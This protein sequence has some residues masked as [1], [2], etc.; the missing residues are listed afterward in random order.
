MTALTDAET[1]AFETPAAPA[2]VRND[3]LDALRLLAAL[4]VVWIHSFDTRPAPSPQDMGRFAVPFFTV[5]SVWLMARRPTPREPAGVAAFAWL[6]FVRRRFVRL[7]VPFLIWN[8]VYTMMREAKLRLLHTGEPTTFDVGW[9]TSGVAMQLWFLPFLFVAQSVCR[10]VLVL[11]T[12]GE[13]LRWLLAVACVATVPLVVARPVKT[14][15]MGVT[16]FLGVSREAVPAALV[17]TAVALIGLHR[18]P[19]SA[20]L[21]GAG[22]AVCVLA[23]FAVAGRGRDLWL[24]TLAGLSL[25]TAALRVPRSCTQGRGRAD[26]SIRLPQPYHGLEYTTVAPGGWLG[27]LAALG[28]YAFGIYL[29]H[30]VFQNVLMTAAHGH[31]TMTNAA[32]VG[33]FLAVASLSLGFCLVVVRLPG[34]ETLA[35]WTGIKSL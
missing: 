19:V 1:K 27:G 32:H 25:A 18:L 22:M 23:T 16:F 7:Y 31:V 26:Q 2:S 33:L 10:A 11:A 15:T 17:A 30:I 24:E 20:A 3:F 4:A 28:T 8:I 21:C 12:Y 9:F 6:S 13:S 29:V 14:E 34:G 35:K 5:T